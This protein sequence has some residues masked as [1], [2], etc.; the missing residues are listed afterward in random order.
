M[1]LLHRRTATDVFTAWAKKGKDAGMEEHHR[2]AVDE[3]LAAAFEEMGETRPF[4]AI[5]AG[6]GNGWLVRALRGT[7]GCTGATGVDGASGMIARARAIDPAG[8]YVLAD[9]T[10][11]QP[12]DRVD[13]VVSMEV[14]YYFKHPAK[15]LRHIATNWLK[16]G[17][18]AVMGIDHYR[19][20]SQS[21][22]W[23]QDVGVHMTTWGEAK[24]R[25]AL[26]EAGFDV[27][28]M[29]RA[30]SGPGKA[31]TLAM[32][33]RTRTAGAGGGH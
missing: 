7:P 8:D 26:E 16:P 2:A 29:W 27:L 15:L 12:G 17:G 23:P 4:T 6:C 1:S 24:W 18:I 33:A 9:L 13:I 25:E 32:L 5:D 10:A 31:G 14:L 30:A 11:W 22:T 28:R 3:M 20:N 19:E 21:L